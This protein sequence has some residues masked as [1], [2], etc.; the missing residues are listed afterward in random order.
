MDDA[1]ED[2][3][4]TTTE[5]EAQLRKIPH[6]KFDRDGFGNVIAHYQRGRRRAPAW[7]LAAQ[8]T[9]PVAFY[10]PRALCE[11]LRRHGFARV[12]IVAEARDGGLC[13]EMEIVAHLPDS[14]GKNALLSAG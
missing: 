12:E 6:V 4:I 1:V 9:A 11:L 10:G 3:E 8:G 14:G 5:I 13:P 7:G 2:T